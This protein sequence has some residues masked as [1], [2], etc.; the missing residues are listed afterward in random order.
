[1][2]END[3]LIE[4]RLCTPKDPFTSMALECPVAS[5]VAEP[6]VTLDIYYTTQPSTFDMATN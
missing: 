1:M 3:A 6:P 4:G 2:P 5:A